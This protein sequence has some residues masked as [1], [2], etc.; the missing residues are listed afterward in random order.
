M[1]GAMQRPL[2][3]APSGSPAAAPG[4]APYYADKTVILQ[5]VF[6]ARDVAPEAGRLIVDGTVYPVIDDVIVCLEPTSWPASL[7]ARLGGGPAGR[8]V[9]VDDIQ[10]TFGREWQTFRSVLSEDEATFRRYFDLIDL[11]GLADARLC[12]LGCGMGRWSF[13]ASRYCREI[14]LVDFSEA[15]FVAREV[16]RERRNAIFVMADVRPCRS[17]RTSPI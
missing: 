5:S 15:I 3:P 2:Q 9:V 17:P 6:G 4:P 8:D 13:F 12:D 7:R 10:Y 14:V 11:N 16:M 1:S